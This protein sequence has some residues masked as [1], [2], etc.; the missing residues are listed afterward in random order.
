[1]PSPEGIFDLP[2]E[3]FL[4]HKWKIKE[5]PLKNIENINNRLNNIQNGIDI[6]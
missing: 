6:C 1:V 5:K 4:K 2:D 3:F